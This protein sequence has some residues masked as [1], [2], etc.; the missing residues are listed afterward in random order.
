[1]IL[2][3]GVL[4]MAIGWIARGG[5][6]GNEAGEVSVDESSEVR[7]RSDAKRSRRAGDFQSISRWMPEDEDRFLNPTSEA[8]RVVIRR[9]MRGAIEKEPNY[10]TRMKAVADLLG[11][12]TPENAREI[13]DAFLNSRKDG[14]WYATERKVF[15]ARY[16]EVLGGEAMEEF[17]D[18]PDFVRVL[19][20]W[21]LNEPAE[22]VDWVNAMEAGRRRDEAINRLIG[23]FGSTD[24]SYAVKVF[25]SLS[26]LEQ[27]RHQRALNEAAIRSGGK[28]ACAQLAQDLLASNDEN[29]RRAG[30]R[31]LEETWDLYMQ[32]ESGRQWLE[33]LPPEH[34]ALLDPS[35]LPEDLRPTKEEEAGG[36][37]VDD[38][39]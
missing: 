28:E 1:M 21:A 19:E 7:R 33:S 6:G 38:P 4:G 20:S 5:D 32:F 3:T 24:V 16:G 37:S 15:L 35:K 34:L 30:Q 9:L 22:A 2:A 10:H 12:M 39:R 18:D 31:A 8:D 36:E 27:Q 26:E 25:S 11:M 23:A 29:I 14:F 17:K 13:R